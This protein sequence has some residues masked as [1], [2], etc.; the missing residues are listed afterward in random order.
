MEKETKA[1]E[2]CEKIFSVLSMSEEK[3]RFNKLHQKL[4]KLEAKMT[5]PTLIQHLKHL[6]NE[7]ILER[8]VVEKQNIS[9][10]LCWS[11]FK[12]LA[13]AKEFKETVMNEVRN[14]QIF[15]SKSIEDQVIYVTTALTTAELFYMRTVILGELE[16]ENKLL[17]Y[18]SY[19]LVRRLF[20]SYAKWL[21]DIS[22]Q[23][24]ET[25]QKIIENI[26]WRIK[27]FEKM[28]FQLRPKYAEQKGN[29]EPYSLLDIPPKRNEKS[30]IP[31]P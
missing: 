12:Q 22:K 10:S 7:G 18:L 30:K 28:L 24:E 5:K 3:I 20:N 23:S 16:P 17:H 9:Y 27:E 4:N 31:E 15:K 6:E 25:A 13:Q 26:D 14:E 2:Y 8:H 19:T 1:D 21:F 11:K 29:K